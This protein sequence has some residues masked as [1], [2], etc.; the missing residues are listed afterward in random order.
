MVF[1]KLYIAKNLGL[2][3]EIFEVLDAVNAQRNKFAHQLTKSEVERKDI[4]ALEK[5]ADSIDCRGAKVSELRLMD[6]GRE[7]TVSETTPS[8]ALLLLV[9]HAVFGKLRNFVF[10]DIYQHNSR[11]LNC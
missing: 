7:V 10:Y 3:K 2:P 5:L 9:L 8:R 1:N 4:F 6:E 11:P